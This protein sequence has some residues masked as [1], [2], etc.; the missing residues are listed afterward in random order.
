MKQMEMKGIS[1]VCC[2]DEDYPAGLKELQDRPYMLY[3]LGTLP[4]KGRKNVAIIG[5][6]NCSDYGRRSADYFGR[7][8]ARVGVGIISGMAVGID[9]L[10]QTACLKENGVS[11]GILGSG[12][13][14]I[15]P[16]GNMELYKRLIRHGG[17]ISEYAPG[18]PAH[19]LHF[20]R[21]NRIISGLADLVLVIEAREKSGTFITVESALEQ[22]RDVYAVPGR[23]EDTLST[24]CNRLIAAGA[25]M[26]GCAEDVMYALGIRD[27]PVK[28]GSGSRGKK[29]KDQK[30]AFTGG[31]RPGIYRALM[32]GARSA[33]ALLKILGKREAE[34]Q[35]LLLE[36]MQL[37]ME[38]LVVC[39]GGNYSIVCS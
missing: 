23:I 15:Y 27:R 6:R 29:L 18:T 22:G 20:P 24:G 16:R 2:E 5:S 25:G 12:V 17:V 32:E 3:H 11:Y 14:V 33:E 28:R 36:L 4:E 10:A 19:P 34:I 38:G 7:E 30:N 1:C 21:R 8:L 35:D 31:S 9:G 26:A 39:R 37:E 13:D